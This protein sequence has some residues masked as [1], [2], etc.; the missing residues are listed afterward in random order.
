MLPLLPLAISIRGGFSMPEEVFFLGLGPWPN[1]DNVMGLL[2][3]YPPQ[4]HF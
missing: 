4:K 3:F 2:A 1:V